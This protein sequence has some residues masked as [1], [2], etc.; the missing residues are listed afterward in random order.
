MSGK[1]QIADGIVVTQIYFVDDV[2]TAHV[3]HLMD[4]HQ[5]GCA[6]IQETQNR[7]KPR[8]VVHTARVHQVARFQDVTTRAR[9]Q[10]KQFL[11]QRLCDRHPGAKRQAALENG[12]DELKPDDVRSL[13]GRLAGDARRKRSPG[14]R[15]G[16][17]QLDR[18][19]GRNVPTWR[20][21]GVVQAQESLTKIASHSREL[22]FLC[23]GQPTAVFQ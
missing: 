7:V 20:R 15:R 18:G 19:G 2:L 3:E 13:R 10:R 23:R 14:R 1:A 16:I 17:R 9:G 21:R 11:G 5:D 6:Q 22:R 8:G 12:R 4:I